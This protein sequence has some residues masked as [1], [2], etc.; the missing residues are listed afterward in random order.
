MLLETNL[1]EKG[2]LIDTLDPNAQGI[3]VTKTINNSKK[4]NWCC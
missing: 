4:T 2:Q 3:I 1:D